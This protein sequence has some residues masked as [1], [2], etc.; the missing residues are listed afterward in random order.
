MASRA[1]LLQ[2]GLTMIYAFRCVASW[3]QKEGLRVY[4]YVLVLTR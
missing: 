2:P 3:P 1:R 4:F